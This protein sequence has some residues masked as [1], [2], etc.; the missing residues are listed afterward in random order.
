ML[1][2]TK[3]IL[4]ADE[5]FASM[6][7]KEHPESQHSCIEE[8]SHAKKMEA[9]GALAGGMAHDMNN[10]LASIMAVASAMDAEMPPDHPY[11]DDV[12]DILNACKRGSKLTR[13]LLSFA[14][15]HRVNFAD[16]Q[17]NDI[18]KEVE[19]ILTRT[20]SKGIS[21]QTKL[22]ENLK[23]I[24]ADPDQLNQ[25]LMNICLNAVDAMGNHGIIT[26]ET[27]NITL[28]SSEVWPMA[29][30]TSCDFVQI[31][32]NDTG[33][34]IPRD[35]QEK[36]FEPFFST[37]PK[38]KGTGLGLAMAYGTIKKH[39]GTIKIDNAYLAGTSFVIQ[40]P[41]T[42]GFQHAI[43][44]ASDGKFEF[45]DM[46][47]GTILLIDDEDLFRISAKRIL[48]KLGYQ[49][50]CAQNG[51]EAVELFSHMYDDIDIVVL[52]MIMPVMGGRE[53]F[54]KLRE[55]RS[56]VPVLIASGFTEED[57]IKDILSQGSVGFIGKPFDLQS[58]SQALP[59]VPR[60]V[61]S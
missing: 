1:T 23:H 2:I 27:K 6:T 48:E 18:V 33:P 9:L 15:R 7:S 51:L 14:R 22:D 56:S 53:T 36:V 11:A 10:I 55:I 43:P 12:K 17:A 31:S 41:I 45:S 4:S 21:I 13:G 46:H 29:E 35:I 25:V 59:P 49:V 37:K 19:T 20:I 47:S 40:I 32:I 8:Q 26:I 3:T 42:T 16:V 34:G 50:L 54:F 38:G 44:G 24:N 58:L 28:S 5:I 39:K 61:Q 60:M 30:C 52:D 57:N